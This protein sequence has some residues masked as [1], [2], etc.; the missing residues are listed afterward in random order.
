VIFIADQEWNI[1]WLSKTAARHS[2]SISK[3]S[4]VAAS[5][6]VSNGQGEDNIGLQVEGVASK[7]AGDNLELATKHLAK[8]KKP[9]P[10]SLGEI[11][12]V[13]QSWYCLK[14]RRLELIYEP[15]FGFTKKSLEL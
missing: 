11:L 6:T 4:S 3:N 1:Y 15:L 2:Q 12:N 5:I 8:R 7:L 9:A 10:K 14:P 13:G